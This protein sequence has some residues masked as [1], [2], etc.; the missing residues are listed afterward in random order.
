MRSRIAAPERRAATVNLATAIL[1]AV[2]VGAASNSSA[3]YQPRVGQ[4]HADFVLPRIDTREP[5]S[6][7]QFRGKKVLLVHFASW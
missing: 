4:L 1:F 6:L 3:A 5:I 7:S 2:A